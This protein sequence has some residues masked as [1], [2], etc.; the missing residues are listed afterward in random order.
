MATVPIDEELISVGEYLRTSYSPDREYVDGRVE[1]RLWG[2][3]DHSILQGYFLFLFHENR[4]AWGV[5][6][7][8]SLRTQVSATR[9]RVPDVLVV[10]TGLRFE[11]ILD[12]PPLI[13]IE[14]LSPEDDWGQIEEKAAD[15]LRFGAEHFWVFDPARR[16]VWSM[17]GDGLHR[18]TADALGVPGAPISVVSSE[19]F[20]EL[21]RG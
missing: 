9:V 21:D 20:A 10:R 12:Q 15:F 4:A 16:A 17:D 8:P 5:E 1:E 18:V 13:V 14:V 2:E 7:F 19:V 3:M 11:R 6:V